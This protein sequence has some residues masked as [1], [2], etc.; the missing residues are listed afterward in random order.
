MKYPLKHCPIYIGSES[1]SFIM[2][3][4]SCVYSLPLSELKGK[5]LSVTVSTVFPRVWHSHGYTVDPQELFID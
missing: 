4:C 2:L 3:I 5:M 1:F